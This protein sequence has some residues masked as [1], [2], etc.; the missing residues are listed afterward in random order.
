M[1]MIKFD[2]NIKGFTLIELL[3]ALSILAF[4][5]ASV[6]AALFSLIKIK[7]KVE[8]RDDFQQMTRI[9]LDKLS[10]DLSLA[11]II[12]QSRT[13]TGFIGEESK[14]T[15]TTFSHI[16][17]DPD[18]KECESSVVYYFLEND[19]NNPALSILKRKENLRLKEDLSEDQGKAIDLLNG[20]SKL[21]MGYFDGEKFS[22][23]WAN[24]S[25][26]TNQRDK[27]P[28]AVKIDLDVKDK[29][30]FEHH[31]YTMVNLTLSRI[32]PT[33]FNP[34]SI[35]SP[36]PTPSGGGKEVEGSGS[37]KEGGEKSK[38]GQEKGV[39]EE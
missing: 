11:F 16:A 25:I 15:F 21:K 19:P 23:R 6:W 34:P 8:D 33:S 5:S 17:L 27:I 18:S 36:T 26:E 39:P 22:D 24:D 31:F 7:E 32:L 13:R 37:P 2:K 20:I 35:A 12:P 28:K 10:N 3:L 38:Q 14:L 29:K 4:I 9:V 1:N 30:G